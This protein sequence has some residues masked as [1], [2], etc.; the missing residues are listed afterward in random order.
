[1][2]Q[3]SITYNANWACSTPG[4]IVVQFDAQTP[5]DIYVQFAPSINADPNSCIRLDIGGKGNTQTWV[6]NGTFQANY[7]NS[8]QDAIL[9]G[10][11]SYWVKLAGNTLT[12]GKGT[13]TYGKGTTVGTGTIG[14]WTIPS[15]VNTSALQYVAFGGYNQPVTYR[16]ISI[17]N[18][19][20][21]LT[22]QTLN[23]PNGWIAEPG[24]LERVSVGIRDGGTEA[25][26]ITERGE[27]HRYDP[28]AGSP[29]TMQ[30]LDTVDP[31]LREDLKDSTNNNIPYLVD[32]SV[33]SD[34]EMVAIRGDNKT[35]I[36]YDWTKK[37]WEPLPASNAS[38]IQLMQIVI[39]NDKTI[40]AAAQ[41]GNIYSYN[42]KS[43]QQFGPGAYIAA[44]MSTANKVIIIGAS[45]NGRAYESVGNK[46]WKKLKG[47]TNLVEITIGNEN[48]IFGVS[49]HGF[50]WKLDYKA[51]KWQPVIC[52]NKKQASGF[53]SISVNSAGTVVA[54]DGDGD[55]YIG[56]TAPTVAKTAAVK[57]TRVAAVASGKTKAKTATK[58][59]VK[60][61]TKAKT[62]AKPKASAKPK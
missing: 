44:G 10:M 24:S 59:S 30:S 51:S 7:G 36:K 41:D 19:I 8:V 53:G 50:L 14:T 15:S 47:A 20:S 45:D 9:P 2:G 54:L 27:L 3:G 23:I 49:K 39:V 28:T 48:N 12:Y 5:N 34:G 60:T 57:T 58:T 43:W 62:T 29:Y 55:N 38:T 33:S 18:N 37:I 31:W 11:N 32:I 35:A 61:K 56:G 4:N 26:G 22:P 16:N 42:G 17:A 1:M 13:T 40:Y 6:T 52:N 21:G 25:W 46:Q